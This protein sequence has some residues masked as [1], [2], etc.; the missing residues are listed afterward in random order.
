MQVATSA[1]IYITATC[2]AKYAEDFHQLTAS[3]L[4]II[5]SLS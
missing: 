5:Q 4:H 1:K 2:M 3:G